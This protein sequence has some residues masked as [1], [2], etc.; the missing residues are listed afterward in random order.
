MVSK[1]KI[2]G[3]LSS[4][5][6]ARGYP[7]WNG[8]AFQLAWPICVLGGN[9]VASAATFMFLAAH[10]VVAERATTEFK[11]IA[12]TGLAGLCVDISLIK[13]GVLVW[14]SALPPIWMNCL[15]LLFG[16]TV[17]HSFKWFETRLWLAA[18]FAGLFAPLSYKAGTVLTEIDLRQPQLLSLVMIGMCWSLILP[19]FL[20]THR[21]FSARNR[22]L[23][24]G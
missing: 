8:L 15:W 20:Y 23:E 3:A 11:F 19:T 6:K 16:A 9:V 10:L 18:V 4:V 14:D 24:I 7:L 2:K 5:L 1:I 22:D 12:V 13:S 17:G 21:M